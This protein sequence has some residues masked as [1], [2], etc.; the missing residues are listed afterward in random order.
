MQFIGFPLEVTRSTAQLKPSLGFV[1][2]EARSA[3]G[4][5]PSA[6]DS[7]QA[8][9]ISRLSRRTGRLLCSLRRKPSSNLAIRPRGDSNPETDVAKR[10]WSYNLMETQPR[11]FSEYAKELHVTFVAEA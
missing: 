5:E 9:L 8:A 11:E 6:A 10:E 1:W 7:A 4:I 2:E 3:P